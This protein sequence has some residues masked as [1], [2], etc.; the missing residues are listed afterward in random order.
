VKKH[1]YIEFAVGQNTTLSED[2][3]AL[4]R[5]CTPYVQDPDVSHIRMRVSWNKL[6]SHLIC[7]YND[8]LR[9]TGSIVRLNPTEELAD[10]QYKRGVICMVE[11]PSIAEMA[12]LYE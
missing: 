10:Y 3:R 9:R 8:T 5:L 4:D 2:A 1:V 11:L 12:G 7:N 6:L